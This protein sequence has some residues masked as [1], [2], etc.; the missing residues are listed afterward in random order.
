MLFPEI[1]QPLGEK[2]SLSLSADSFD[3][4]LKGELP[5]L[6]EWQRDEQADSAVENHECIVIGPRN[7]RG[8][9]RDA[10]RIGHAPVRGHGLPR[11]ERTRFLRGVVAH[12]KNKIHFWR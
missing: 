8:S 11:P 3:S 6:C 2:V 7:L 10:R 5:E 1:Q 9:S 4:A 12:G